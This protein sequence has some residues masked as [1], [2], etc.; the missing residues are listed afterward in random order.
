MGRIIIGLTILLCVWGCKRQKVPEGVLTEPQMVNLLIEMYL[1]E[2]RIARLTVSYDSVSLLIPVFRNK[3][4]MDVGITEEDYRKSMAYYMAM[5]KRLEYIYSA[6]VDSLSLREQ[7][8]PNE[9]TRYD[10][11]K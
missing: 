4:Y 7:S 10:L 5:P 2:E 6:V 8:Q 1:A 9:Y 3:V 11:P